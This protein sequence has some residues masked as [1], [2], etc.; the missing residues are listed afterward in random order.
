MNH[1]KKSSTAIS[2]ELEQRI[3]KIFEDQPP[4]P[5]KKETSLEDE[6]KQ[7]GITM[8]DHLKSFDPKTVKKRSKNGTQIFG[9]EKIPCCGFQI[10]CV[11]Y[12]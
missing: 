12:S 8:D 10:S 9:S 3:Q 2:F 11:R 6:L 4:K 7:M 1:F 5:K